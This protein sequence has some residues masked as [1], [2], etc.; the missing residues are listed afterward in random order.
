MI[1]EWIAVEHHRLHVVETW[2]HSPRKE[3]TLAAIH[4]TLSGLD[5]NWRT[6]TSHSCIACRDARSV[7]EFPDASRL[8][9]AK[10]A[11]PRG[12]SRIRAAG[13]GGSGA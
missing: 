3:A 5:E 11:T 12:R 10:E 8:A 13:A 2:P 4:S 7:V 6:A 9:P 1:S